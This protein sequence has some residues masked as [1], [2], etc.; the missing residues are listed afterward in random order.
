MLRLFWGVRRDCS[1]ALPQEA[2]AL[3]R[4]NGNVAIAPAVKNARNVF[5][6]QHGAYTLSFF[7]SRCIDVDNPRVRVRTAQG[8]RPQ[9]S[10]QQ[11]ICRV[12]RLAGDL[13]LIV[14]SR[15]WLTN[16]LIGHE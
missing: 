8:L 15:D 11:H 13:P 3:L 1:D 6:G 2:R 12:T 5:A 4:Q 14:D 9:S 16:Y 7:G 10:G